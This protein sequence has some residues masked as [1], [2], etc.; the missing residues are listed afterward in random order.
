MK[1]AMIFDMDGTLFQTNQ[2]L[3]ESLQDTFQLLRDKGMWNGETP[4]EAYRAIMGVP[5][6]VV[7]ETLIPHHPVHV[8][9]EV[10]DLFQTLLIENIY[11]GKGKL[12]PHTV[13]ILTYLSE[14]GFRIFVASN[15]YP[16]YLKAI[17]EY[18][19]LDQWIENCY[20]IQEIKSN[21]KGKLIQRIKEEHDLS[22]GVVIGDRLS[23][24][25]GARANDL[26][27]IGCAFDF[28][29]EIELREADI[30]V[31]DLMEI[32]EYL[33]EMNERRDSGGK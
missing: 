27:S 9:T 28:S 2:I 16:H 31:E 13:E 3:E 29:Q 15:G 1:A 23:D 19:Q 20:S 18:Y 32:K 17:V 12:Y 5:L 10:N 24:F 33:E 14:R 26:L 30:V 6:Y 21:D 11:R 22:Y 25:E 7:W 8:H 4:V